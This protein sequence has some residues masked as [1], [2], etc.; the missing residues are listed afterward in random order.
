MQS[1][2]LEV[3]LRSR[4]PIIA[5]DSRDESLVLKMLARACIAQAGPSVPRAPGGAP[6]PAAHGLPLF[7]WT[8]TDGLRRLDLEVGRASCRERVLYRV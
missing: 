4:V 5:V 3:L 1:N 7:Q 2:D 6:A 8:V